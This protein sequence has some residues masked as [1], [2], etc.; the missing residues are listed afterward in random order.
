MRNIFRNLPM[1]VIVQVVVAII[2]VVVTILAA[3][4]LTPLIKSKEQLQADVELLT[5]KKKELEAS[6]TKLIAEYNKLEP[7]FI[8]NLIKP[9]ASAKALTG[10]R[11]AKGRQ[12]FELTARLEIAASLPRPISKVVYEFDHP[13]FNQK[14]MES[15]EASYGYAVTYKGWGCLN[16]VGVTVYF[17]DGTTTKLFFD[18]CAALGWQA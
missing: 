4:Q 11:D 7:N 14:N 17:D 15:H 9:R 18:M 1:I 5:E 3:Y 2:A 6:N 10:V 12:V 16:T 8:A 13:T